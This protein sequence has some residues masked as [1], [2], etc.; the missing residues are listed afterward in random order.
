MP[1]SQVTIADELFEETGSGDT[2]G[3]YDFLRLH[4]GH[5]VG[6]RF[7][8]FV[9]KTD[10]CDLATSGPG[11]VIAATPLF[12]T[13]ELFWGVQKGYDRTLSVDQFMDSNYLFR[14]ESQKYAI[15]FGFSHLP[16]AEAEDLLSGLPQSD[17]Q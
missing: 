3:F 13:M 5:I 9:D 7:T 12:P 6:V 1:A 16:E 15:T 2:N 14:S 17:A 11:L 4:D 8:P 10:I